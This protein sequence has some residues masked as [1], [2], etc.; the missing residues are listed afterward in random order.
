MLRHMLRRI[1]LW[2]PYLVLSLALVAITLNSTTDEAFPP[3]QPIGDPGQT[4]VAML[5]EVMKLVLS[6][7]TAMLGAAGALVVKGREW[8]RGWTKLESLLMIAVFLCGAVSFFGVYLCHIAILTMVSSGSIY[9][10]EANLLSGLR[11]QYLGLIGGAFLLGLVFSLMLDR[12][13]TQPEASVDEPP[14][15]G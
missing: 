3:G 10:L 1:P 8:S 14:A 9:T 7:S 6:L 12:V 2:V 15:R 4:S 5:Q 13:R 11:F